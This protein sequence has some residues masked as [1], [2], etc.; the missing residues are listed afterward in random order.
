MRLNA[1][2]E[3]VTEAEVILRT[4]ASLVEPL[5]ALLP[6]ECEV[7]LHDLRDL[8]NSVV[9]IAGHLTGQSVGGPAPDPLQRAVADGSLGTA[10]SH[11]GR[12]RDGNE[13]RS[14]TLIFRDSAGEPVAAL[15]VDNDTR[16]WQVVGELARSML[17][18][19]SDSGRSLAPA[20]RGVDEHAQWVLAQAIAAAR[21]PVDLM[22]KRH[23]IGVV[24]DLKERGFFT[25]REGVETAAQ[26]LGVT[27]FTV[28][29]YLN[30]LEQQS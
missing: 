21:V 25:L 3:Y 19:T 23:K 16:S 20:P 9:A 6:G 5:A 26:A 1:Y 11:A 18:W 10:L 29:N 4:L 15:C 13:L 17:P 14:S 2:A 22:Q 12:D 30:E 28:Y 7:T 27:R 24:K 8:P